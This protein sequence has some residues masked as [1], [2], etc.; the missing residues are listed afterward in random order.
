M[1][2]LNR[3]SCLREREQPPEAER[4][5]SELRCNPSSEPSVL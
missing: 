3:R 2:L 4:E 1:T 5:R